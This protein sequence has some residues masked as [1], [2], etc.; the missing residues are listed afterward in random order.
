MIMN[1][2]NVFIVFIFSVLGTFP[3]VSQSNWIGKLS[4]SDLDCDNLEATYTLSIKGLDA[5][6]WAL[7]DQNYRFFF[8]AE[9]L[10]MLSV[11]SLLPENVYANAQINELLEITG[12]GQET[13]SPLDAIDSHLGFLDFN[14]VAYKKNT[15]ASIQINAL[16]YTPIA[17]LKLAVASELIE[18]E[19]PP[20]QIYFSRAETAGQITKQFAT[21]SEIDAP[22]HTKATNSVTFLDVNEEI[23]LDAQLAEVCGLLSSTED[24][25]DQQQLSIFPNP[26]A[27]GTPLNYETA[28]ARDAVHDVLVY[29]V[30]GTLLN[31]YSKLPAQNKQIQLPLNLASGT[32]FFHLKTDKHHLIKTLIVKHQ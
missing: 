18:A 3:L 26:H 1:K 29:D 15:T 2:M 8:D 16:K 11:Q 17:E 22:N 10:S 21:I 31:R 30:Q 7:G 5:E 6:T 19:A 23:G 28:L 27:L 24:F 32:Y 14:I 9:N 20:V 12:Q 25:L 4:L 13:F